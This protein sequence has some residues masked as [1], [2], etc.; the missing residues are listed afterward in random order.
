MNSENYYGR[1]SPGLMFYMNPS[2]LSQFETTEDEINCELEVSDFNV[3]LY[4][5]RQ[6]LLIFEKKVVWLAGDLM[7]RQ[8]NT[9]NPIIDCF[10][11]TFADKKSI[12]DPISSAPV[13]VVV[14]EDQI[15]VYDE[16]KSAS[17][18]SFPIHIYNAFPFQRG[19]VI[20]KRNENNY[21][22]LT[23][24][25]TDIF[26]N[27]SK[28][29]GLSD[30]NKSIQT[31]PL[32]SQQISTPFSSHVGYSNLPSSSAAFIESNFL[33]LTDPIDDLG[34][35][36]SSS[37]T[38]FSQ[39]EDLILYPA[40]TSFSLAA[41]YNSIDQTILIYYTRYLSK[42]KSSN[43]K[44]T[45]SFK[46]NSKRSVSSSMANVSRTYDDDVGKHFRATSNPLSYDRMAS[47]TEYATDTVGT[48]SGIFSFASSET[49]SLRK[50]VIFTKISSI[51]FKTDKAFLKIFNLS[52]KDREAIV[53]INLEVHL[54]DI[55]IFE[56]SSNQ[57]VLSKFKDNISLK[58]LDAAPFNRNESHTS[59]IL[60]LKNNFEFVI[61]NPFY[62][63]ISP[64]I[65]L[66]NKCPAILG[67]D[68]IYDSEVSFLCDDKQHYT[69][70]LQTKINNSY[71]QTYI[72]SLKYLS[73]DLIYEKF[74][75]QWCFNLSLGIPNCD[76]WKLFIVTL[77]SMGLPENL[78]LSNVDTSLNEITNLLPYVEK[79][80]F[81]NQQK[82]FYNT[83]VSLESLLPKIVLALHVIEEDLKLNVLAK[84]HYNNLTIL[85][86][87][88]VHWMSWS[89]SWLTYY[90]VD[91]NIVDTTLQF[92]QPEYIPQP[93]NIMESLS[94]LFT[95]QLVPYVTFSLIAGEE[96]IVDKLVIPR[97]YNILR[98]FEVIVSPEFQNIDLIRT[99]V[100]FGID[101]T[102]IQTYPPGI[103]FIFKNT[104]ALCQQKLKSSSNVSVEE[105][106]LIGRNDLLHLDSIKNDFGVSTARSKINNI[107][108]ISVSKTMK[109][110]LSQLSTN[111]VLNAWD[112]QAEADKFHVTR[113]IF[114]QD[115]RFYELTKL[116]QTSKVQ[117]TSFESE[118]PLDDY[119][120]L[121][122][123][124]EIAAKI[125]LRTLT[126]PIGRGAVFNSSRKPLVTEGFPIPKMNFTT[127]FLPDNV[128]VSL[129]NDTIPEY[130]IDWG[131]FHNG[132][133]AGLSVSKEFEGL[134]GSWVVFNR[135]PVLNAQHAG[136]L[137]GLGLNGHLKQLEE[138]HIY[139]YLGPKHVYTSIGLLL[140]MAASL[141]GTMN[142]K[143]TKVLS[144]HVVAFLP[145]GSTNLNVQLPV[146]TAGII[147]IG[148]VYLE[149]QHR[150]MSEV[151]LAQISSSLVINDKVVVS[152]GYQLAAGFA[153]GYINLGKGDQMLSA[154]SHI[155][156]SLISYGT[157]IRDIQTLKELDK[158]CSGAIMALMFM[159]LKTGNV[160]IVNKIRLPNTLQLLEYVR[161]D[162]LML[163]SLAKNMILWNDIEPTKEFVESQ[164]PICISSVY[165]IE[166][167]DTL[168][169]NIIPY[170]NILSGELLSIS[171]C[172]ASTGNF[173]AKKTL[174]YYLDL[175]LNLC[176]QEP[177][178]Y[179]S[180]VALIGIRNARDV[181]ILGLSLIMAGTGDLD[182][183]RRLRYLQGITDE[184]TR[185]GN[186]MAIN[187]SLGFLFL[188]GG[189][190]AFNT[191]NNFAIAALITS[192][193]PL[194]GCNNYEDS[195]DGEGR[196]SNELTDLHLQALRHFWA[197]AIENRCLIIRELEN[198]KPVKVDVDV[199]LKDN[200]TIRIPAPCLLPDL[201]L[202]H[203][204]SINS[205]NIYFPVEFDLIRSPINALE[206]FKKKLTLYVDKK[207]SYNTLKLD[208]LEM[209]EMDENMDT[210]VNLRNSSQVGIN[211]LKNLNIF[212]NLENFE[213]DIL[214]E[215]VKSNNDDCS[216][217]STVFDF[218]FEIEK[219]LN[220]YKLT[221]DENKLV[222][223]RLIFNYVDSF[224]LLNDDKEKETLRRNKRRNKKYLSGGNHSNNNNNNSND[225]NESSLDDYFNLDERG[226]NFANEGGISKGLSY[227][228]I[229]FIERLKKSLFCRR[230]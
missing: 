143:I 97:T 145:P 199:V 33:T 46:K 215:S 99:M 12:S 200:S 23:N 162:L 176:F 45:P 13:L 219:I 91:K 100:S 6:K 75:L 121:L 146:Q 180:K 48:T 108:N 178:N 218:K 177:H 79:A 65:N 107:S 171:I 193:Y 142:I 220:D 87:Q 164:I 111:E 119:E 50:D 115:R 163:R 221:G 134:S 92:S 41:T 179:D 167:I 141:K 127:L 120:K 165:S 124:R 57:V 102:D 191:N 68:S 44:S 195:G 70:Y 170:I 83:D 159:F 76:D 96:E 80:R 40:T 21:N 128:N 85:L 186:Y 69:L 10:F 135:P 7:T 210:G 84:D 217:T 19:I 42:T 58:G 130:L 216:M 173:E 172:F 183:M 5:N 138:W 90:P 35:I 151:L 37:T 9:E 15:R 29:F 174:L 185:Y 66:R 16:S 116:L 157:S 209:V 222:N 14:L 192:I 67:I 105:L 118:T 227:L 158:S 86:S 104:I 166:N 123:Q 73:H 106:K 1:F 126:T 190:Q 181:V 112:G 154:H 43:T 168:E 51:P 55:Y 18:I 136:F 38:S 49:L 72:N 194:F 28:L 129:E 30:L 175:L 2:P 78:D 59:H 34:M 109:E 137:L 139:N 89:N 93:P 117:T 82:G 62:E 95:R 3:K 211:A 156:T 147:G 140:G 224:I 229:E 81:V 60:L 25:S 188:G 53:I 71:V 230:E 152:E 153:L 133:S 201:S 63:L 189:Q 52:Y 22:N 206:N 110:I 228:N 169:T 56:K 182:V 4:K 226:E 196:S 8:I 202:I 144:V 88:L 187:M 101:V 155:I 213:K 103:F 203:K 225:Y 160:E 98:L 125:A 132:A 208:F 61:F 47:G 207:V 20:G 31:S 39:Q 223:L 198:E 27:T 149:T 64:S 214:F 113:L 17:I 184:Y 26:S 122:Q 205:K 94:S 36:V 54:I 131:Y 32:S 114:S 197:L 150:R 24:L 77:L 212:N 161:P 74:W 11:T 148:L 204:I